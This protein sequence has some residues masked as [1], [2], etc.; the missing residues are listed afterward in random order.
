MVC[1]AVLREK[2]LIAGAFHVVWCVEVRVQ[3][4]RVAWKWRFALLSVNGEIA[5]SV[6]A[7]LTLAGIVVF[8]FVGTCSGA[9]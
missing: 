2:K 7:R 8:I 1:G 9:P 5:G 6:P 4:L 3:R